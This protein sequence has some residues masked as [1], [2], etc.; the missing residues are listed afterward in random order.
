M[1]EEFDEAESQIHTTLEALRRFD[2]PK[3]WIMPNNDAGSDYIRDGIMHHRTGTTFLYENLKRQ[4][5]LALLRRARCIVGNSSSGL[6]EAPTFGV[7]AVNIGRRQADRLR[8]ANVIDVPFDA[9]A[10]EAAVRRASS[11]TFRASL[12]GTPNPYGD[13]RSSA[14]ILDI[15]ERTPRDARLLAKQLTH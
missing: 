9:D 13:G 5:Y 2:L 11:D 4:Y 15:L 1:T 14:R 12:D 3:V 7:P 8:G 10:I 6:L